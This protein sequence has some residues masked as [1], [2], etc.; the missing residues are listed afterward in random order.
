MANVNVTPIRPPAREASFIGGI[1]GC[2]AMLES[3]CDSDEF[4]VQGTHRRGVRQNNIVRR[5]LDEILRRGD[6]SEL[7]GFCAVLTEICALSDNSG[8]FTRIFSKYADRRE[9][10]LR[11]RYR[12][13]TQQSHA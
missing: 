7:E 4:F 13:L 11:R 2:V 1:R 5:T 8:D 10:V 3:T 9:R 12:A 6:D